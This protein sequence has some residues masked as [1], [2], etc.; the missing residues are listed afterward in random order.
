M[1]LK[2]G[3]PS[4]STLHP[5]IPSFPH[6]PSFQIWEIALGMDRKTQWDVLF[7][8]LGNRQARP[9]LFSRALENR[10]RQS[11]SGRRSCAQ[12]TAA[13]EDLFVFTLELYVN[14]TRPCYYW[15]CESLW[16]IEKTSGET[17]A[18]HCSATP[19]HKGAHGR[20]LMLPH[21]Q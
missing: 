3:F 14:K 9:C 15:T 6:P 10:G 4:S 16:I 19:D 2:K 8:P 20:W 13:V 17:E 1:R 21:F 11:T 12:R 5:C 18:G 7:S